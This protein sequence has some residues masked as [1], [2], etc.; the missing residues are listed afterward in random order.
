MFSSAPVLPTNILD[1]YDL[2][3]FNNNL[4]LGNYDATAFEK[5]LYRLNGNSWTQAATFS[6]GTGFGTTAKNQ[7][8]FSYQNNLYCSISH[9]TGEGLFLVANDTMHY[10]DNLEHT[11]S[12]V[13]EYNNE[14]TSQVSMII[15]QA[16]TFYPS[17][18]VSIYRQLAI[19]PFY[20]MG[21]RAMVETY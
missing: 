19:H 12:D 2:E 7:K 6:Q 9:N 8:I 17:L 21:L 3:V 11:A 20:C 14:I 1:V 5:T 10:L 18:T 15:L 16:N 13:V 4:Y